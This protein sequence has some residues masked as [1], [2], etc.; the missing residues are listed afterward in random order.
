MGEFEDDDKWVKMLMGAIIVVGA[1]TIIAIICLTY[2]IVSGIYH[3]L[4]KL[5]DKI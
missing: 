5:I 2:K 3:L 4:D 1:S